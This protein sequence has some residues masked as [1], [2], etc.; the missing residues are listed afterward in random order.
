MKG[1]SIK[2]SH[3]LIMVHMEVVIMFKL[4]SIRRS[5]NRMHLEPRRDLRGILCL[6]SR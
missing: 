1:T 6:Q 5:I 3:P 4:K 2:V